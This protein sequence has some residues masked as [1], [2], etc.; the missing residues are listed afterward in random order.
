MVWSPRHILTVVLL[1][2]VFVTTVS[3]RVEHQH[4]DV[5]DDECETCK[6]VVTDLEARLN[7]PALQDSV[8]SFVLTNVCPLLPS[9]A[10]TTCSQEARVV[11]AQI[12][13]SIQQTF[14]PEQVCQSM[15][16]CMNKQ[17]TYK[18]AKQ[19]PLSKPWFCH[20]LE[21]PYFEVLES[22]EKYEKRR[23]VEGVWASTRV[24]TYLYA[25]A[26]P[27]GFRRLF[28]YIDEG[29]EL[30]LKIPM[31][32]PVKIHMEP[33]CGAF[34][35]QNFTVSFFMPKDWQDDPPKPL[36]S[37][38]FIETT[39]AVT[40]YV[41]SAGGYR[42]DDITVAN[43]AHSLAEDLE[44]DGKQFDADSFVFAGYDPPFRLRHRHNEVWLTAVDEDT[45]EEGVRKSVVN[46]ESSN[47]VVC[48]A[49]H[50]FI[51]SIKSLLDSMGVDADT[52]NS[53]FDSM[54]NAC[55]GIDEEETKDSC[56][57]KINQVRD[58]VLQAFNDV[59]SGAICMNMC[60]DTLTKNAL[61]DLV[62]QLLDQLKRL[63][64]LP[65]FQ[66]SDESCD[67]CKD[68]IQQAA[69]IIQEPENQKE[70]FDFIKQGCSILPQLEDICDQF[71]DEFGPLLILSIVSV[72]D[73]DTLCIEM[74]Y[75]SMTQSKPTAF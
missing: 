51:D 3:S 63:Q 43:M 33:S 15:G 55:D 19:S 24:E 41:K 38:I 21:C 52:V 4:V 7:D 47:G 27:M 12:A 61:N 36:S 30:G 50:A 17:Q 58:I 69:A 11:V 25:V 31:T 56:K 35:K 14:T 39:E 22:N 67:T 65:P 6:K 70:V 72:L 57:V 18:P 2:L 60:S 37:D 73:P 5:A 75:C 13:A 29:N 53:A 20:G 40:V 64:S 74:G 59:E 34:C 26:S 9:D 68:V 8:V 49:C 1:A 54:E 45:E 71:V 66:V 16:L 46:S 44:A 10:A 32:S 48:D 62:Q 42:M 23:Y 28:D